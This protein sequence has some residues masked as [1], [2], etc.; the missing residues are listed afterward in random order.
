MSSLFPR[1]E[2]NQYNLRNQNDFFTLFKRSFV[3]SAIQLWNTFPEELKSIQSLGQ[4][5]HE[6]IRNMFHSSEVSSYYF[7]GNRSLSIIHA[8]LRNNC[9]NYQTIYI[10]M[11]EQVMV[12]LFVQLCI[13]FTANTARSS[14]SICF[15]KL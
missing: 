10:S 11:V 3:V 6:L 1:P 13:K 7:Y 12:C 15:G 9:S 5:K 2:S 8:S 14:T 4:F